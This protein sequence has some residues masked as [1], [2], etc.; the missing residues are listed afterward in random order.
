MSHSLNTGKIPTGTSSAPAP[1]SAA[2]SG[3]RRWWALAVLAL[4][5][6][7]VVLD[8][9]I[10]NIALP[11]AQQDLGLTDVERQWVV[12][13]Y[14][15]VFGALLLLGGRIADTWGR[16][17]AFMLGMIGF[18]AASLYGGVAQGAT[19]LIVARGL[20][21]L[22]AALLAPAALALLTVT[23]PYG[24]ERN[25]AFAVFGAVAG[26]GAAVGLLLGGVLTEFAS[27]RWCLLVNLFFVLAGVI[28]GAF[29][30][31]ESRADAVAGSRAGIDVPG[32]ITAVLGFGALVYGFTQAEHGWLRVDTIGCL[33][34]GV[35][36]LALFVWIES[37]VA[38]PLLPLRVIA[39]RV[40]AGAYLVQAV[41][42]SALIGAMLYLTLYLQLVLGM[43]PLIAG[44]ASVVMTVS[45]LVVVP[46]FTRL[47]PLTGP[48][49][50]MVFGPIIAAA[51]MFWMSRITADGTY[52]VQVLPGLLLLGVGLGLV[53]V[54][55]QNLALIGVAPA[56][57]GAASA[58]VN[59]SMQ[60]G[61]SIGLSLFALVAAAQSS[62]SAAA[63]AEPGEAM[64]AG[65]GAV[66]FATG[67]VLLVAAVISAL[68]VRGPKEELM[69]SHA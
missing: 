62:A 32:A 18:G 22:F 69:P 13:A 65:Y 52:L 8:G 47:L 54:P 7:V 36:L 41:I 33:T 44:A 6:L 11:Q 21:G 14:A 31:S 50:L 64:A 34:A 9:T 17:R 25:A 20:Q 57:A 59:A 63:G 1:Q 12:T 56:D 28:V 35:I 5:Q 4:T 40:R 51:G 30:L 27:W 37:R 60:L 2:V 24:R 29:V 49:P 55:L 42:G 48:R 53:F 16:K 66:F 19:D 43:T 67:V 45:T 38:H 10:V 46:F 61:G 58:T 3:R 39:H 26:S 23:F 15:L 68:C